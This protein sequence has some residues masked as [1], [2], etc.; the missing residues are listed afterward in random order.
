MRKDTYIGFSWSVVCF[1]GSFALQLGLFGFI[2]D[3]G[4]L[5]LNFLSCISEPL[6]LFCFS[7]VF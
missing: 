4:E 5:S 3:L 2:A 7:Y 6:P 1:A